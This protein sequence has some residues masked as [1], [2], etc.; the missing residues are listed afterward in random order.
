MAHCGDKELAAEVLGS[1]PC[2]EPSQS[3]PLAPPKSLVG[4]SAALPQAKQPAGREPSPTISRQVDSSFTELCLPAQHPV[5]T[6]TSPSH[7]EACTSLLI[8]SSTRG[9]TAE[10]I[11]TTNLQ[12]AERKPHSQK[13]RQNEKAEDYVPDEGTR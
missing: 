9:Q 1:T 3:P 2:H 7:Q 5:L 11:R 12:P 13:D 8:V 6:S 4:S 10:A